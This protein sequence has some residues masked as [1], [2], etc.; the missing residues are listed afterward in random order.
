VNTNFIFFVLKFCSI[1]IEGCLAKIAV[2]DSCYLLEVELL[3][4]CLKLNMNKDD[5]P[6]SSV[7]CGKR[8]CGLV[9]YFLF[10][11]PFSF[12]RLSDLIYYSRLFSF[13]AT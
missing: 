8:T 10:F 11:F 6:F 1:R 7:V 5:L 3:H 12:A 4:L 13:Q 9:F 2:I